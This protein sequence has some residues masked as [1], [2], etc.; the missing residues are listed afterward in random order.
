MWIKRLFS[1]LLFFSLL[2]VSLAGQSSETPDYLED[3]LASLDSAIEDW[4]TFQE[5]LE[6]DSQTSYDISKSRLQQ[7]IADLIASKKSERDALL[8]EQSAIEAALNSQEISQTS[9]ELSRQTIRQNRIIL[10]TVGVSIIVT[11]WM[12]LTN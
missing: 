11:L 10:T 1:G 3:Y 5:N 6:A 4:E 9:L 12:G 2:A 7:I 8:G